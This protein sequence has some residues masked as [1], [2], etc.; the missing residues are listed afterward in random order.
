MKTKDVVTIL[1]KHLPRVRA[2]FDR[3]AEQFRASW[4]TLAAAFEEMDKLGVRP[5]SNSKK[6]GAKRS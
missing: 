1:K 3:D 4:P 5:S 2:E 6:K